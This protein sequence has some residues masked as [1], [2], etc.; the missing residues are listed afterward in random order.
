MTSSMHRPSALH[1][2][3]FMCRG[4]TFDPKAWIRYSIKSA[5]T[6]YN[7]EEDITYVLMRLASPKRAS[8]IQKILE[9][10]GVHLVDEQGNGGVVSFSIGE[11][12]TGHPIVAEILSRESKTW[13]AGK[14]R[15]EKKE[16][17]LEDKY[18][19]LMEAVIQAKDAV[20]QAKDEIIKLKD[21]LIIALK[22]R[23]H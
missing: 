3:A 1:I 2:F 12:I 21:E 4:E 9:C 15:V 5:E 19:I 11:V 17:V 20:I 10:Q 13:K 16:E 23:V 7:P 22:G 18:E 6:A 14:A 8:H